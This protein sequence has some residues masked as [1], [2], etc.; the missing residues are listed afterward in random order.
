MVKNKTVHIDDLQPYGPVST[1][2][3]QA[4]TLVRYQQAYWK[5]AKK[6]YEGLE[7]VESK[8]FDFGSFIVKVQFN[9]ERI[10]ST[11]A[12]TDAKSIAERPC[13]LCSDNLP[14]EQRGLLLFDKYLVLTNPFPIFP[15]HLTIS[16][17]NHTPQRI[18]GRIDDM[19]EITK[20]LDGFTVFYNGP[21][22]GA[23]APDH[24]HFQAAQK[25]FI[26]AEKEVETNSDI[27]FNSA[28]AIV[29]SSKKYLRQ[30]VSIV[31][32]EKEILKNHFQKFYNM[33]KTRGQKPEPMM[34]ILCQWEGGKWH[35][36]V[37]PRDKQRPSH[38]YMEDPEKIVVGPAAVEMGGLI[39]LPRKDDFEKIT[40]KDISEIYNEV[41][42]NK[43][44]F[45]KLTAS[46]FPGTE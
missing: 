36:T 14:P 29:R 40:K 33:L 16:D 23:S 24:F 35:L 37:F 26:P 6:N 25:G 20:A 45:T 19:L 15:V 34:N 7:K 30:F 22:C 41:T 1:F 32:S 2:S 28:K 8:S 5:L 10:R 39:I 46:V 44:N 31:S 38:F 9:P 42:I 13:F 11:A 27:I 18:E 17:F 4:K 3:D 43:T 12:K 21:E